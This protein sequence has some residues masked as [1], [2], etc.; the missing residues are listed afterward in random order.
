MTEL[1]ERLYSVFSKFSY[2]AIPPGIKAVLM[3][4]ARLGYIL[5]KYGASLFTQP[6]LRANRELKDIHAGKRCFILGNGPSIAKED[7]TPLKNEICFGVSNFYKHPS[8]GIIRPRYH[9]VPTIGDHRSEHDILA[10]FGEMHAQTLDATLLLSFRQKSTVLSH[11]LFPGRS[12]YFFLMEA[13]RPAHDSRVND[14][15]GNML[16]PQSVPVMCLIIALYMGCKEIYLLGIDHD[17]LRTGNYQYF[18]PRKEMLFQDPSVSPDGTL[19]TS[20]LQDF[21]TSQKLWQQYILLNSVARRRG[22][23]IINISQ[24]SYLDVFPMDTLSNILAGNQ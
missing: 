16:S 7:L 1:L 11:G 4:K 3:D 2:W 13:V 12:T 17:Y 10:W 22:A 14:I 19:A 9:C 23:K 8:Y 15:T 20:K 18:F 6:S 21:F 24:G 5:A